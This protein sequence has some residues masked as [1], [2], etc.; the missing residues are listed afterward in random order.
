MSKEKRALGFWLGCMPARAGI[1]YAASKVKGDTKTLM[2]V[3]AAGLGATWLFDIKAPLEFGEQFQG[4][5]WW[6]DQR[7]L[8]GLF[9]SMYAATGNWEFLAMDTLSGAINWL[10]NEERI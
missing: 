1:S 3:G 6:K 2:R 10:I 7:K 8:H 9:W 4:P 5:I